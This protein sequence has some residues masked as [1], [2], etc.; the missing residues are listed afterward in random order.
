MEIILPE[1]LIAFVQSG[2]SITVGSR[3]ARH[4]PSLTRALACRV[5]PDRQTVQLWL[6]HSQSRQLRLDCAASDAIAAVFSEVTTD[7][8]YQIK[9]RAVTQLPSSKADQS[10]LEEHKT[11]FG[12][13]VAQI[14][15]ARAFTHALMHTPDDDVVVLQFCAQSVFDQTPGPNAGNRV[16]IAPC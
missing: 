8:T 6:S 11:A 12:D 10:V 13:E 7:R 1:S 4:V 5:L 3:D 16:D 9:G 15:F 14:G 2:V